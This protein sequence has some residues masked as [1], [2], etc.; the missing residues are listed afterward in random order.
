MRFFTESQFAEFRT[1]LY[2]KAFEEGFKK[3]RQDGL[4]E[5]LTTNK[6]GIHISS[7][8]IYHFKD[9]KTK[10]GIQHKN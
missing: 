9:G 5:G 8:G 6:E 10:T 1:E 7:A 2:L 3:G 4:H